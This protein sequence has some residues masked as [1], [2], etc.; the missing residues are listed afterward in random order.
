MEAQVRILLVEPIKYQ[1]L[2]IER[3]IHQKVRGAVVSQARTASEVLRLL[4]NGDIEIA[5]IDL[6]SARD[7]GLE[8]LRSL[9]RADGNVKIIA[10]AG[11][12][13]DESV[14]VLLKSGADELL[15]KDPSFHLI[16]P[17]L[18]EKLHRQV[19][20]DRTLDGAPMPNL[21]TAFAPESIST[22]AGL[23]AHEINNPLMSILGTAELILE[24]SAISDPELARK[25]LTIKKSARRIRMV[26]KRLTSAPNV[27]ENST[28]S[29][30][31]LRTE[32]PDAVTK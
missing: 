24:Q 25:M 10:I 15:F 1:G 22:V 31:R 19:V 16:I 9:S 17:R 5:I 29:S 12:M 30:E 26:L 6:D 7:E 8:I 23:L 14:A 32:E 21:G 3:E 28:I 20:R 13:A 18:I 27:S 2:L 11:D 4:R